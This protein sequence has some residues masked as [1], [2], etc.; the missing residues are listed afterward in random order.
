[1]IIS[2]L[3]IRA[4]LIIIGGKFDS[5]SSSGVKYTDID[6]N[7]FTDASRFM[8]DGKSPYLRDTYRYPPLLALILI[9]NLFSPHFGK[10]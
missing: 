4:L 5:M 1:M 2:A 7:V 9:P 8:W 10:V 3:I 6:Y